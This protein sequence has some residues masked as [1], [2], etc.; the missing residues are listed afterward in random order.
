MLCTTEKSDNEFCAAL[1]EVLTLALQ[2]RLERVHVAGF[3]PAGDEKLHPGR[4]HAGHVHGRQPV[5][6]N[7]TGHHQDDRRA[8]TLPRESAATSM[9]DLAE[10]FVVAG[11]GV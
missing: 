1:I 10:R 7:E 2:S 8:R 5:P 9:I 11:S 3:E 6:R 4:E